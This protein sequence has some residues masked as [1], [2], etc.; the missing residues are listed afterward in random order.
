MTRLALVLGGSGSLGA[1]SGGAVS[2]ILRALERNRRN[3][4]V[5]VR[6]VTGA[7]AG[8]I[9]A[10]TAARSLVINPEVLPW[11]D[12]FWLD[13]FRADHLL[14]ARR[15]DRSGLLDPRALD[16]M[17]RLLVD[18]PAAADD[19]PA[20]ALGSSLRLGLSLTDLAGT[21]AGPDGDR[22]SSDVRFDLDPGRGA[23]DPVWARV[24]D[25][26][27]ASASVP[28]ILPLRRLA[29]ESLAGA[30]EGG[31]GSDRHWTGDGLGAERPL[32][33]ARELA[34]ESGDHA[35]GDWRYVVVEPR[36][37]REGAVS[38]VPVG[39]GDAARL[40]VRASLGRG[41][42]LDLLRAAE[43]EERAGLLRALVRRLPEIHGRLEDSDAVGL[44]RRIGELAEQVAEWEVAYDEE[45]PGDPALDHLDRSLRKLQERPAYA[46]AFREVASRAG[47]TRLAKLVLVL[48]AAAGLRDRSGHP[49]HLVS[50]ERPLAGERIAGFGGLLERSWRAADFAAG[51]RAARGLLEGPLSD[52]VDYPPDP[53]EAY[54]TAGAAAELGEEA[55]SLLERHLAAEVDRVLEEIRPGGFRGLFFGL[56]R[57]ALRRSAARRAVEAL[58]GR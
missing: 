48:E 43:E 4:S 33:L 36:L 22:Y 31:E 44:G 6:V 54:R 57:P 58:R 50:P 45:E 23:G 32:S 42:E 26:A 16:E 34:S 3:R 1:F 56:A 25:A 14:D 39:I 21:A 55:R 8:A 49:V 47:R 12:R 13:G 37:G 2:E 10:A 15:P 20:E 27:L 19:R 11:A 5:E 51:R 38:E 7:S 35:D 9:A 41:S 30:G 52:A 40:V 53:D 24:A 29:H 28:V 17:L 46:P 18:G